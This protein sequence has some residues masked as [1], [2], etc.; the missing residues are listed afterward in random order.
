MIKSFRLPPAEGG[1]DGIFS[2]FIIIQRDN[3]LKAQL[4]NIRDLF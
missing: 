2:D 3:I 1:T 4:V